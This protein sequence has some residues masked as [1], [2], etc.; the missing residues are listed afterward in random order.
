MCDWEFRGMSEHGRKGLGLG[1]MAG[2]GF[3]LAVWAAAIPARAG[4]PIDQEPINY[5]SAP[6][7][8]PVARL[9]ARIDRGEVELKH[10]EKQGYLRSVLEHLG[11]SPTSQGLVFSKTSFQHTRI[12]PRMPRAIYFGDDVYV[13]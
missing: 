10:D 3:I 11:V 6:T 12:S 7:V 13:G 4:S 9:Q 5:F 2:W 8:D 1:H